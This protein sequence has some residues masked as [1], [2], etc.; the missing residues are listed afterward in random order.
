MRVYFEGSGGGVSDDSPQGYLG[1]HW[2]AH[3]DSA[4]V[5]LNSQGTTE[6]TLTVHV[7]ATGDWTDWTPS[8]AIRMLTC[9]PGPQRTSAP[10]PPVR[11]RLP[12]RERRERPGRLTIDTFSRKFDVLLTWADIKE[13]RTYPPVRTRTG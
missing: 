3:P 8:L 5:Y 4:V 10:P 1:Q 11:R 2:W 12:L 6:F 13:D 7:G 9:S